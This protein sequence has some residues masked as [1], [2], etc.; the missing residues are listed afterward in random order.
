MKRYKALDVLFLV[1]YG[2]VQIENI[3]QSSLRVA[4]GFRLTLDRGMGI[5][6]K[7]KSLLSWS[8][9]VEFLVLRQTYTYIT[10]EWYDLP[11]AIKVCSQYPISLTHST[12]MKNQIGLGFKRKIFSALKS[13]FYKDLNL[14]R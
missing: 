2:C 9:T 5:R 1:G 4:S 12:R 13:Q 6:G 11:L 8:Y 14:D 3:L 10:F 7:G